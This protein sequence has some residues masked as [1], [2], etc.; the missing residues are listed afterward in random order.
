MW[1]YIVTRTNFET[2]GKLP[3]V[4]LHLAHELVHLPGKCLPHL[5][6]LLESQTFM[7][8][9]YIYHTF[10]SLQNTYKQDI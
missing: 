1:H 3:T 4:F 8:N 9:I 10:L 6:S 2:L 7:S 5:N